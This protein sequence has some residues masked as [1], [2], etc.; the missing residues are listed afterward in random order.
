MHIW[1]HDKRIKFLSCF[2]GMFSVLSFTQNMQANAATYYIDGSVQ[3]RQRHIMGQC[4]EEL[5]QHKLVNY[6]AWRYNLHFG[7]TSGLTY[8]R[9]LLLR[10]RYSKRTDCDHCLYRGQS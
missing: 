5:W 3:A 1:N 2:A 9:Y 8:R 6:S 7:G 4:L 10:R